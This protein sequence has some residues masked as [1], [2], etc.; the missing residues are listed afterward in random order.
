MNGVFP[1]LAQGWPAISVLRLSPGRPVQPRAG[2]AAG[3]EE[4]LRMAVA[5]PPRSGQVQPLGALLP[6]VLSRYQL[7]SPAVNQQG[8]TEDSVR[9]DLTA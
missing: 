1:A 7:N 4:A 3:G 5:Y 2:Q 8:T 6:D 9:L